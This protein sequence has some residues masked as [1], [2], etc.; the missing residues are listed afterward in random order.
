MQTND[1]SHRLD[2]TV[3]ESD[4]F[5]RKIVSQPNKRQIRFPIVFFVVS[6][7]DFLFLIACSLKFTPWLQCQNDNENHYTLNLNTGLQFIKCF[8]SNQSIFSWHFWSVWRQT[9]ETCKPGV[10]HWPCQHWLGYTTLW[11]THAMKLLRVCCS[12][13]P[14]VFYFGRPA[15]ETTITHEI[16]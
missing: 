13:Q 6:I 1:W 5:G 12:L 10:Y 15:E 7:F 16:T 9:A 3:K 4:L 14:R 11:H 8:H 2:L